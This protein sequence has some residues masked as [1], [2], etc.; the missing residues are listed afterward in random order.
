MRRRVVRVHS[1]ERR[2]CSRTHLRAK[3]VRRL[4]PVAPDVH[5]R[6]RGPRGVFHR[7]RHRPGAHVERW[8]L[9]PGDVGSP[10]TP[11]G[12]RRMIFGMIF[13]IS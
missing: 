3:D 2:P 13:G 12:M 5:P 8:V 1:R 6:R 10:V 7:R 4:R 9:R 11:R